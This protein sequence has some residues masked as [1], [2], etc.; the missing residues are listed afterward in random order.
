MDVWQDGYG[1]YA[2][3]PRRHA[4][5]TESGSTLSGEVVSLKIKVEQILKC[6]AVPF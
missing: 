3:N 6:Q 2:N 1:K 4:D 5:R